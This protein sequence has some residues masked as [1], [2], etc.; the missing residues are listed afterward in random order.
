MASTTQCATEDNLVKLSSLINT[1]FDNY[2]TKEE[3]DKAIEEIPIITLKAVDALPEKGEHNVIYLL[4]GEDSGN[5][6]YNEYFWS[7]RYSQFELI[8]SRDSDMNLSNLIVSGEELRSGYEIWITPY[9]N[10]IV[11]IKD[12][13]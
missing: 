9:L 2:Y 5:N 4:V 13:E 7:E 8:G 3:V 10:K 6:V 12:G 1:K 11:N